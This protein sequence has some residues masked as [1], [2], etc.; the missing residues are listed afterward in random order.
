MNR[1]KPVGN[2]PGGSFPA[3][4]Q[5]ASNFGRRDLGASGGERQSMVQIQRPQ[6]TAVHI[7]KEQ[8]HSLTMKEV[9]ND[10]QILHEQQ[11]EGQR[12]LDHARLVKQRRG[13]QYSACEEKLRK[14]NYQHG[15][16]RA[17]QK[18]LSEKLS[19]AQRL[20]GSAKHKAAKANKDIDVFERMLHQAI[21]AKRR[22]LCHHWG[23]R[24]HLVKL[25]E[26]LTL[27]KNRIGEENAYFITLSTEYEK[28]QIQDKNLRQ[29]RDEKILMTQRIAGQSV[30]LRAEQMKL[31]SEIDEQLQLST[32]M[33]EQMVSM[34]QRIEEVVSQHKSAVDYEEKLTE[35]H[36]ESLLQMDQQA[37]TEQSEIK[38]QVETIKVLEREIATLKEV[39]Q[40]ESAGANGIYTDFARIQESIQAEQQSLKDEEKSSSD[41]KEEMTAIRTELSKVRTDTE[42]TQKSVAQK[43]RS[44]AE[45]KEREA[46]RQYEYKERI[47]N[48]DTKRSEV[49]A[50]EKTYEEEKIAKQQQ[51]VAL[52]KE[53]DDVGADIANSGLRLAELKQSLQKLTGDVT[54][55]EVQ[56][57]GNID[58]LLADVDSLQNELKVEKKK[59]RSLRAKEAAKSNELTDLEAR[60]ASFGDEGHQNNMASLEYKAAIA[61]L[62]DEHP[63]LQGIRITDI[64]KLS[65]YETIAKQYLQP[66][67]EHC[68]D[69]IKLAQKM[70]K[71]LKASAKRKEEEFQRS[72]KAA[73]AE[74]ER[75]RRRREKRKMRL[76]SEQSNSKKPRTAEQESELQNKAEGKGLE[77]AARPRELLSAFTRARFDGQKSN[78]GPNNATH[79]SGIFEEESV[80][81]ADDMP[82]VTTSSEKKVHWGNSD[83][84]SRHKNEQKYRTQNSSSASA[85]H[86]KQSKA[87]R[88]DVSS[89]QQPKTSM[90]NDR[91]LQDP[92]KNVDCHPARDV[93]GTKTSPTISDVSLELGKLGHLNK[94]FK[95]K[96]KESVGDDL[97]RSTSKPKSIAEVDRRK[98]AS[99]TTK[100]RST[101]VP[102]NT[103]APKNNSEPLPMFIDIPKS[104]TSTSSK[105]ESMAPK[106]QSITQSAKGHKEAL[107]REDARP[108]SKELKATGKPKE[109]SKHKSLASNERSF[110]ESAKKGHKEAMDRE[111]SRPRSKAPEA[112]DISKE[113]RMMQPAKKGHKKAMNHE[114]T[115]PRSKELKAAGNPKESSKRRHSESHTSQTSGIPSNE[116]P[117]QSR[118]RVRNK[119]ASASKITLH[120]FKNDVSF[121][122]R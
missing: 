34:Q 11:Q 1:K 52:H 57:Q 45:A 55:T 105:H 117:N 115:H 109:S 83:K 23:N 95:S 122:F 75:Q 111:D 29:A 85:I 116:R 5:S 119:T 90:P 67:V 30:P 17:F 88:R 22:L 25:R 112:N 70:S 26:T 10:L 19:M 87:S 18:D 76:E 47:D 8:M 120:S 54:A 103:A 72:K 12:Q 2:R 121:N 93:P 107:N 9:M 108:R 106:E 36:K 61:Q 82:K 97:Q 38:K 16:D 24:L 73:E 65:D 118:R 74:E 104:K 78:R 13:E 92:R 4:R 35:S 102:D 15:Q 53:R 51:S 59:N 68:D 40:L 14:L 62:I 41:V 99:Q 80:Q 114:E 56:H 91:H 110:T 20:V 7:Q 31:R 3:L 46:F 6:P 33:K 100:H 21:E 39:A 48:L 98:A 96:H 63:I 49:S 79:K 28:I 89:S 81:F 69:R 101:E 94:K 43:K 50:L 77:S 44:L 37:H 27:L 86:N 66:V 58:R 113:R 84:R 71:A 42:R 64:P 60:L 32:D